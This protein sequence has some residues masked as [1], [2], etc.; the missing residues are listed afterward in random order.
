MTKKII[1][2]ILAIFLAISNVSFASGENTLVLRTLVSN[3]F[4][5]EEMGSLPKPFGGWKHST[6]VKQVDEFDGGKSMHLKTVYSESLSS[7]P[8]NVLEIRRSFEGRWIIDFDIYVK[9][10]D[11]LYFAMKEQVT[12]KVWIQGPTISG[13]I[14]NIPSS[15]KNPD[16]NIGEFEYNTWHHVTFETDSEARTYSFIIDDKKCI[17]NATI[18]SGFDFSDVSF[19]IQAYGKNKGKTTEAYIDKFTAKTYSGIPAINLKG[20]ESMKVNLGESYVE[21]GFEATDPI[22][23]DL[24]AAVNVDGEVDTG[25]EGDYTLCYRVSASDGTEAEP[26]YRHVTVRKKQLVADAVIEANEG[27]S[28]TDDV[29]EEVAEETVEE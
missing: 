10:A 11:H 20:S 23:G 18:S 5:T 28:M 27:V 15:V 14:V 22:D 24:T 9:E 8:D 19:R 21:P 25:K 1:S 13:G 16:V 7:S 12:N 29:A 17:D 6:A 26:V 4:E 2:L 3:D